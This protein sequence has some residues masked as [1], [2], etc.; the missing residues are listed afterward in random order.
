MVYS[1]ITG[2]EYMQLNGECLEWEI[3]VDHSR[4]DIWKSKFSNTIIVT[5]KGT[6]N[7]EDLKSD[8]DLKYTPCFFVNSDLG[9]CG[10]VHNGFQEKYYEIDSLLLNTMKNLDQKYDIYFT[11]HSLGG[12]IALLAS[13]DYV[14]N[15]NEININFNSINCITFGQPSVGDQDFNKFVNFKLNKIQ[16]RRYVNINNNAQ[17]EN[18]ETMEDPVVNILSP[19]PNN[20]PILLN[21]DNN[22]PALSFGL[23]FL[24]LYKDKLYNDSY[25]KC[26]SNCN[27]LFQSPKISKYQVYH[28]PSTSK[29]IIKGYFNN[30][31]SYFSDK[32]SVC[33]FTG[34]DEYNN[35]AYSQN[36]ICGGKVGKSNILIDKTTNSMEFEKTVTGSDLFIVVENHNLFFSTSTLNFNISFISTLETPQT[37]KDLSCKIVSNKQNSIDILVNFKSTNIP[38]LTQQTIKYNIYV[39]EVGKDWNKYEF[40]EPLS[41]KNVNEILKNV[42]KLGDYSIVSTSDNGIESKTSNYCFINSLDIF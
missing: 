20:S 30:G 14:T 10:L 38:S 3:I 7:I 42:S 34:K 1:P 26:N 9:G 8:M 2:N 5:F 32:Y 40:I 27:Y 33:L 11:G 31:N 39:S 25:S 21:C 18:R 16:Y 6:G 35:Y 24:D 17:L 22:C 15:H 23:H 28:C 41:L 37:P 13:L 12:S 4:M 29:S 36:N 19:H